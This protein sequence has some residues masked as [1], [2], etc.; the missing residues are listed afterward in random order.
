MS[1]RQQTELTNQP[2]EIQPIAPGWI[3]RQPPSIKALHQ[4]RINSISQGTE[5]NTRKAHRDAEIT[6]RIRKTQR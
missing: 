5:R 4:H 3:N 1:F 6:S 2:T